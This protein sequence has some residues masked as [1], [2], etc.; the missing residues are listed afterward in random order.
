MASKLVTLL[1]HVMNMYV[2]SS[3]HWVFPF[4]HRRLCYFVLSALDFGEFKCFDGNIYQ[5][6]SQF[7]LF[8]LNVHE[9][10]FKSPLLRDFNHGNSYIP[11]AAFLIA[12]VD[13]HSVKY[14]LE[15]VEK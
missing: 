15:S 3:L 9:H 8:I 5:K 13:F 11:L 7:S 4:S 12:F 14:C 1:R 6:L 2:S 10:D